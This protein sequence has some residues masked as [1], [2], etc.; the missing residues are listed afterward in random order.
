MA[1]FDAD[2]P[3]P[4]KR[5]RQSLYFTGDQQSQVPCPTATP[6]RMY[7]DEVKC[8]QAIGAAKCRVKFKASLS[9]NN[10]P[11]KLKVI[12]NFGIFQRQLTNFLL[13]EN[14]SD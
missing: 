6:P 5:F 14:A 13:L 2:S 11:A 3:K 12:K 9:W 1:N 7:K 4:L 10:L 8:R